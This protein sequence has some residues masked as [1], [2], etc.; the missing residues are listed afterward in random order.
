[1]PLNCAARRRRG[2][3]C[4]AQLRPPT[5]PRR[6]CTPAG[7]SPTSRKR[8]WRKA[9]SAS[10]FKT[11][12]L[13]CTYLRLHVNL[14][15]FSHKHVLH[16]RGTAPA[17]GRRARQRQAIKCLRER[18]FLRVPCRCG[19]KG[20]YDGRQIKIKAPAATFDGILTADL[21][22]QRTLYRSCEAVRRAG[23]SNLFVCTIQVLS[24][25]TIVN[26]NAMTSGVGHTVRSNGFGRAI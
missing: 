3:G 23:S 11:V 21:E 2:A 9:A 14:A 8:C 16:V 1:M 18:R 10:I 22:R 6:R 12:S 4:E 26:G 15:L 13:Q 24:F 7:S 17:D 20:A 19:R 5:A 25:G